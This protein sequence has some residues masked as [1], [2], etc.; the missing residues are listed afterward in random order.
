MV[1]L[2][3]NDAPRVAED[4]PFLRAAHDPR[5]TDAGQRLHVFDLLPESALLAAVGDLD[6]VHRL[7]EHVH[8][9]VVPRWSCIMCL[10]VWPCAAAKQELLLDLGWVRL[11][12]YCSILLEQ[13]AH[14][15]PEA[16]PHDLWTRFIAWTHPLS[17]VHDARLKTL[18]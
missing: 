5:A 2:H 15:L 7:R 6:L 18:F 12:V 8:M 11:P 16:Y 13:A 4:G 14:D 3:R 10:E 17:G 1:Q 9:P